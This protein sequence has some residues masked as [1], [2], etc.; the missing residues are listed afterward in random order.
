VI[1]SFEKSCLNLDGFSSSTKLKSRTARDGNGYSIVAT[2]PYFEAHEK[3]TITM[4]VLGDSL[5]K[6]RN[7]LQTGGWRA[8]RF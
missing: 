2:L 3:T 1:Q 4:R 7:S 8:D 6:S 5:E